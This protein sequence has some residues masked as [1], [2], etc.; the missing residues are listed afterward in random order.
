MLQEFTEQI[1]RTIEEFLS[2][3]HTAVPGEIK[4]FNPATCTAS[5]LPKGQFKSP[6]GRVFDYPVI[7]EV[8][9]VFIQGGQD[10]TIAYPIKAGD[11]CLLIICEQALDYWKYGGDTKT[12]LKHDL[13]N[14]VALPGLFNRPNATVKEAIEND[15][16]I[17]KKGNNQITLS[18]SGIAIRGDLTVDGNILSTKEIT[19]TQGLSTLSG[20]VTAGSISLKNHT[21]TSANPGS[22]TSEPQ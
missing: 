13:T 4:Q 9:V 14:A 21:H 11:G 15:S 1:G 3:I 20:D 22:Q 18:Q 6:D 7:N 10:V 8:P 5:I 19:G 2:G 16:I 17:I 12:D